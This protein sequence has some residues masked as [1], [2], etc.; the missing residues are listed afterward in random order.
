LTVDVKSQEERMRGFECQLT[1]LQAE[2][3]NLP[4]Q[5]AQAMADFVSNQKVIELNYD[6]GKALL[7][8][9]R[10]AE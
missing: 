4:A 6:T 10:E 9:V 7:A 8:S 1:S 3:Q 5:K 2:I